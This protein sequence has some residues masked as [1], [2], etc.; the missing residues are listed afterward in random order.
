MGAA[1]VRRYYDERYRLEGGATFPPDPSRYRAWFGPL[2]RLAAAPGAMLDYGCGVGYVCSLFAEIG[3]EVTG[4]DI[5]SAA[6]SIARGRE[7]DATFVEA[8]AD[9][10]LPFADASFDLIACLGV[11]EHI[12]EPGPVVAELRRVARDEAAALWVVPNSRSPFFW[13]G[14]GTGQVEEHPRSLEG[15]RELLA[16]NGWTI[17]SIRRDPGPLDRPMAAWKRVGQAVLN[18]LPLG[19]TYQFVIESRAGA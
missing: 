13:F 6:L 17:E 18:R 14:H 8:R 1:D 4:V 19:L 15:W 3:Y 7:P 2:L 5:S 11:L 9:A 16:A 10:S 12:S